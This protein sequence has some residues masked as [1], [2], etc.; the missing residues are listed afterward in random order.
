M[1]KVL[2]RKTLEISAADKKTVPVA[3]GNHQDI[4]GKG[5]VKILLTTA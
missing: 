5:L 1:N 2:N 4:S 3:I